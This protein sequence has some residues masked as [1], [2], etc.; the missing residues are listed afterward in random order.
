MTAPFLEAAFQGRIGALTL[1]AAFTLPDRGVTAL[2][3]PSGAGKTTLLRAIAGLERLGGRLCVGGEVWQDAGAF[4]P[5]HRRRVGYVFQDQALF[6]H[7]SVAGNLRFA[8][9]RARGRG[10]MTFEAAVAR[11]ELA[12][13]LGRTPDRLSGGEG[14]RVALGRALLTSADLLLLD[15]PLSGLDGE[16]KAE[17][18]EHLARLTRSLSLPVLVVSHDPGEILRLADRVLAL[19]DGRICEAQAPGPALAEA[20]ARARLQGGDDERTARLA[21]A[22]L[23]AGLGPA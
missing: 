2:Y 4:R 19:R 18:M 17:V 7:L 6:P 11:L 9:R 15:E 23:M 3:G 8:E 10:V 14:R 21:L 20:A 13:L 5:A 16:A 22:A 1:D 12:P